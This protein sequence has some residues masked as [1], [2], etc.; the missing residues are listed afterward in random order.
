MNIPSVVDCVLVVIGYL[1]APFDV[2]RPGSFGA[3]G[4]NISPASMRR[5]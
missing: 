3:I 1:P 5:P 2:P 4:S